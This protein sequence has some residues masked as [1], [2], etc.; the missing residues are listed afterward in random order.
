MKH[1][2]RT[3]A[4]VARFVVL[5]L[6]VAFVIGLVWPRAGAL[7]R[8]RLNSAEPQ[9]SI[10]EPASAA[11]ASYADAVAKAAPSVVNIYAN[12]LVTEQPRELY[13]DPVLQRIFSVPSGPVRTRRQQNLGSGVIV[14]DDGYVLTNN[15]VIANADDIQLLLYDG[16]VAKAR[17]VGSDDETDLAVLKVDAGNLP[18]IHMTDT[19]SRPRVGDVVLAIGNPFGI[20]QT[21]TMGIVSAL[22]RQLNLSSLEN[23]IQTDAAINFGNSGGALV[24]AH[25]ELVGI[26]TSLIGQAVGAE[27]IGFAIPVQSARDVLEQIVKTG[28]VVRGWIGADYGAVPVSA[29]SGLPSA[30]RGVVVNEISPGGPAAIAGLQQRDVL[31]KIGG[32]D[33]LDPSDL[34]RHEA[35]LK[36][37][38]TVTVT[39]LRYG[40][41]FS[42]SLTPTQR[43]PSS[44]LQA[45]KTTP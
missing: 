15:H 23:F 36:P 18:A 41:P 3:L 44:T 9:A 6:A 14:S 24:N 42:V 30:A 20:G 12:K 33:I 40:A 28:H 1:A 13:S 8:Q 35:S 26:N 7:L 37:G 17:V 29:D 2:A 10:G 22:G 27:G 25:G 5:G 16:R 38:Q 11:P 31:L 43:P 19:S 45:L 34:R 39:G 32:E 4:F 21:V